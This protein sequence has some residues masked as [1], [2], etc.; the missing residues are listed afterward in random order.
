MQRTA[1]FTTRPETAATLRRY[2]FRG[3]GCVFAMKTIQ[4]TQGKV[5]LVD[6][7]D[8]DFL[9]QWKWHSLK[10]KRKQSD[11][12][13]YAIR[14]T[15]RPNRKTIYMQ[16]EVAARIGFTNTPEV[17]HE[18]RD[19]LNNQRHNLRPCTVSQN[20]WNAIKRSG[21]TSR[22]K[23]VY[24]NKKGGKWMARIFHLGRHHYLGMSDNEIEA[25]RAYDDAAVH[26]FGEFARLNFPVC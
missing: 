21:R 10:A 20:R 18:D 12:V 4:L 25:A 19:G 15:P 24:W 11:T 13:W 23:G 8:Y 26:H 2:H 3:A 16:R 22:F 9:S 7:D 1:N 6:D 17:D 5:A 14:S